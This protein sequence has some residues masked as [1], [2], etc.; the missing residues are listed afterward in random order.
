MYTIMGEDVSNS[1]AL[2]DANGP[3]HMARLKELEDQ[4][5]LL[6]AGSH[7]SI[8]SENPGEAGFS[9]SLIVASFGSLVDAQRWADKDPYVVNG[10]FESICVKPFRKVFPE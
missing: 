9:G 6:I 10:V 4:K 7:P 1:S 2:R 5:R 8:D 3:A